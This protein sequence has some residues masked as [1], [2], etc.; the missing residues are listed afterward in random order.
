[1]PNDLP[2]IRTYSIKVERFPAHLYCARSLGQAMSRCWRAYSSYD[3]SC[4]YSRFLRIA[5][6]KG[7][8]NP[9]GVGDRILVSGKPASRVLNRDGRL[10]G[11]YV[12]YMFD[13]SST[14]L[15]SH[16]LD[17]EVYHG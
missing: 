17:V 13:D 9:P 1:M 5:K 7:V 6:G 11:H 15:E 10:V 12:A 3:D 2:P 14:I 4:D 16:E 8:D